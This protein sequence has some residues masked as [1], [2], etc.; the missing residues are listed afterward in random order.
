VNLDAASIRAQA[1]R[2]LAAIRERSRRRDAGHRDH[3][4]I[5]R[6]KFHAQIVSLAA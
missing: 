5:E 2:E 6:Q 3:G 1:E 4:V